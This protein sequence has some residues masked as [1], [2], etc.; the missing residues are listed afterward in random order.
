LAYQFHIRRHSGVGGGVGAIKTGE[1]YPK[2][3]R[4]HLQALAKSRVR[5]GKIVKV[6]GTPKG[7]GR[8][9]ILTAEWDPY[10]G[11]E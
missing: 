4:T 3:T 5:S 7:W 6:R 2:T 8:V 10:S 9:S 11:C 1:I